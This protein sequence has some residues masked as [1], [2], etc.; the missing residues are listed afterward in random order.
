M[1]VIEQ[2]PDAY[3]PF[4]TLL[5]QILIVDS[6]DRLTIEEVH[7]E[8]LDIRDTFSSSLEQEFFIQYIPRGVYPVKQ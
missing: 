1:D 5:A 8:L 2:I 4:M 7:A 6:N 3:Q